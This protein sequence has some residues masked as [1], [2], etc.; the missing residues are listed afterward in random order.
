MNC[1]KQKQ[2]SLFHQDGSIICPADLLWVWLEPWGIGPLPPASKWQS[3][4]DL[5]PLGRSSHPHRWGSTS[6]WIGEINWISCARAD[7]F[8]PNASLVSPLFFLFHMWIQNV[9]YLFL[10]LLEIIRSIEAVPWSGVGVWR[11]NSLSLK[12]KICKVHNL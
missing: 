12:C 8:W 5:V 6:F 3:V 10:W 7:V 2:T 11:W 9:A 1:I 4:S